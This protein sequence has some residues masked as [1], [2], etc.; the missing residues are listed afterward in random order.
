MKYQVFHIIS[1]LDVGGAERVAISIAHSPSVD[2]EYHIVE[3]FRTDSSF[4][5]QILAELKAKG[6]RVH[7]SPMPVLFHWHYLMERVIALLFPLRFLFLWL[8]WHPHIVHTHTEMPD[9]ATYASLSLMPWVRCK[10]VRTIHNTVLWTGMNVLGRRVERFMQ[11]RGAN[12]AISPNVQQS[13]AERFGTM[14]PIIYNG[15][16]AVEQK[17]YPGLVEGRKNIIFAG[18]LERQKG[19]DVLVEIIKAMRDDERYHF[20]VFGSGSLQ[21]Y[22]DAELR[23]LSNVTV[24]PPLHALSE[25]LA[26]FDYLIMPSVHEGLSILS[27]EASANGLPVLANDCAGLI[28]TLPNGWQLLAHD[29]DIHIWLSLFRDVLP[30]ADRTLLSQEAKDFVHSRFSVEAM[31][32]GYE[33]VYG[34]FAARKIN[35]NQ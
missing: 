7:R 9:V 11:R 18:R 34:I 29:N 31:Q 32:R 8:R 16:D 21:S 6:I 35:I 4:S 5:T 2:Y 26:S 19:I 3:L 17:P 20:H 12:I 30:K 25:K 13:Y 14:P 10:V 22:V 15:V 23:P 33:S 28:D 24:L 1:R 27:L